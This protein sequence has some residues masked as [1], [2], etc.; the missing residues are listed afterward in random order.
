MRILLGISALFA[1][2]IALDETL[3]KGRYRIMLWNETKTQGENINRA[4]HDQLHKL[5]L[6]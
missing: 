3:L 1:V 4:I 2:F 6:R 5:H